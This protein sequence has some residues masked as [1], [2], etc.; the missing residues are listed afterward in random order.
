MEGG[1]VSLRERRL[2]LAVA[3]FAGI[4]L[5]W[6]LV[7]NPLWAKFTDLRERAQAAHTRIEAQ[8]AIAERADTIRARD[9]QFFKVQDLADV[10]SVEASFLEFVGGAANR[11]GVKVAS[12]RPSNRVHA[13]RSS[14][15]S[16]SEI[17]VALTG[18]A[19]LDAFVRFLERLNTDNRPLRIVALS[20]SR[21][22]TAGTLAVNIRLS[23]VAMKENAK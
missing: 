14:R 22:D 16:Y 23:T 19:T 11:A 20:L 1:S 15:P 8:T 4:F 21:T 5:A 17:Q 13:A 3:L 7:A 10:G 6:K 12:E 18:T 9:A 2:A